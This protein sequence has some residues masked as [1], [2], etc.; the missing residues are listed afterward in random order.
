MRHHYM[1]GLF[2]QTQVGNHHK[3]STDENFKFHIITIT[4]YFQNISF[5]IFN[6]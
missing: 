6:K 3:L 5:D 4:Y 2:T 1:E